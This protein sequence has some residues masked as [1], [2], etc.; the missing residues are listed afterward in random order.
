M[1][2]GKAHQN[3]Q[4]LGPTFHRNFTATGTVT[5]VAT[6]ATTGTA[7]GATT[8]SATGAAADMNELA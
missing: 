8:K 4:R 5:G 3:N 2:Q 6:Y 1:C 7:T